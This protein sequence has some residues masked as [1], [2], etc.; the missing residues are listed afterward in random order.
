MNEQIWRRI[1]AGAGIAFVLLSVLSTFLYPQPPSIDSDPAVVLEWVRP[2]RIGL[3]VG[4][5]LGVFTGAVFTC[6]VAAL[7]H[8]LDAVGSRI[9][10]STL[11]GA[12]IAFSAV[13]ALGVL[14]MAALVFIDGQPGGF[15]EGAVVRLLF[16]LNQIM[17]AP[18]MALA[19]VF[20]LTAGI[21]VLDTGS[22]SPLLARTAIVVSVPT[23]L[24]VYTALTHSSYHAGGWTVI[25]WFA[26]ICFLMVILWMSLA[27]IRAPKTVARTYAAVPTT[28]GD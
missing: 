19:V 15:G 11:Y 1:G 26:F 21:A 17:F 8:H 25:G 3:Q 12:G 22:F 28:I 18:A 27:M 16:D 5:V 10:H 9:L 13:Y 6:F 20:L 23:A 24:V 2:H 7:R 4:M 14:P